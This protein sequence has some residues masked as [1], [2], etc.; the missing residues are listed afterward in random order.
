MKRIINKY[1]KYISFFSSVATIVS[2]ILSFFALNQ[3][4]LVKSELN[5]EGNQNVVNS[6]IY[7]NIIRN[8]SDYSEEEILLQ[9]EMFFDAEDYKSVIELYSLEKVCENPVVIT[10]L[11][12]MYSSG[13][14]VEKNIKKALEKYNKAI[15]LGVY[16]AYKNKIIM[17]FNNISLD[18]DDSN[19]I[20]TNVREV[21]N[22][23]NQYEQ[24]E[25]EDDFWQFLSNEIS[26]IRNV[27]S[28][29][30]FLKKYYYWENEGI[31]RFNDV[32]KNSFYKKYENVHSLEYGKEQDFRKYWTATAY[33]RKNKV[34]DL[35]KENFYYMEQV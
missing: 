32:P 17:L 15:E 2:L 7:N 11:A 22:S 27:K 23:C 26:D 18:Y 29:E 34:G 5:I 24:F 16:H 35:Y 19:D 8:P 25:C 4:N 3:I 13:Y 6:N 20:I 31:Q 33:I 10:N 28:V 1:G 30:E 14:G 21:I 9:A 12:Y